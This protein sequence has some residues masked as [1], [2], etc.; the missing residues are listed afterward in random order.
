MCFS[1]EFLT[2]G[3]VYVV[4]LRLILKLHIGPLERQLNGLWEGFRFSSSYIVG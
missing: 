1:F 3:C 4:R 2:F